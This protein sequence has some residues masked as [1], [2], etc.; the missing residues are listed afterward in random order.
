MMTSPQ[1]LASLIV[2]LLDDEQAL[3]QLLAE[4]A[5]AVPQ[6][7]ATDAVEVIVVDGGSARQEALAALARAY[8]AVRWLHT[9]AGRGHQMNAGAAVARGRWLVFVHADTTLERG[10]L[11]ALRRLEAEPDVAGGAFRFALASHD[12][13]ARV[14]EWGVARRVGWFGLPYGDQAIFVRREVFGALGGYAELPIMEDVELVRR[15]S[16]SGRRLVWLP[17]RATTSA[18][19][20]ERDGWIRRSAGNVLLV[21]RYF[22]GTAPERLAEAYWGPPGRRRVGGAAPPSGSYN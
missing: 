12:W 17:T 7:S 4:V 14:I 19:R 11:D 20:W 16:A 13:R 5:G 3:A 1:P 6:P 9:A 22:A 21:L 15:L 10:W 2:P 8:P 18:R